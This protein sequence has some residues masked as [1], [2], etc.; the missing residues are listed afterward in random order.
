MSL[1]IVVGWGAA[2]VLILGLAAASQTT[3]PE[4]SG[5]LRPTV[6]RTMDDG[7]VYYQTIG[8]KGAAFR[9]SEFRRAVE[10][11]SQL[12]DFAY[13]RDARGHLTEFSVAVHAEPQVSLR[14]R[15]RARPPLFPARVRPPMPI[16]TVTRNS[17]SGS[18]SA[19]DSRSRRSSTTTAGS[20]S[21][22]RRAKMKWAPS[23]TPSTA[24]SSVSR[25]G[26]GNY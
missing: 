8:L 24:E 11:E 22:T 17:I 20:M 16:S 3:P 13:D 18:R 15:R 23:V 10:C 9:F 1:K 4:A 5:L 25:T 2:F 6:V 7:R 14:A 21:G 26:S 12:V 19:P